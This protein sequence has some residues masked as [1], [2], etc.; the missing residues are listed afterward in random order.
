MYAPVPPVGFLRP[1]LV[2]SCAEC[3]P[4]ATTCA[5]VHQCRAVWCQVRASTAWLTLAE[6][7]VF[8]RARARYRRDFGSVCRLF[9]SAR[10]RLGE[11][12]SAVEFMDR[13]V[14]EMV[15][16]VEKAK[17]PFAA[18]WPFYVLIETSGRC[19]LLCFR[20]VVRCG[21]KRISCRWAA[22]TAKRQ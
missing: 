4:A 20:D 8:T 6:A 11:V 19:V 12:L 1:L 22:V 15:L 7:A 9:R 14:I 16:Q 5:N 3:C 10:A 13:H 21:W 17:D 2:P 18:P